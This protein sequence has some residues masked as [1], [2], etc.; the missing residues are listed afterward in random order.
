MT[1]RRHISGSTLGWLAVLVALAAS[2][3]F[4]GLAFGLPHTQTRPDETFIIEAVRALLSGRLPPFFDYPWMYMWLLAPLYVVYYLVGAAGGTFTSLADMVASWPRHWEPFFLIS[5]GLSATAGT[6]T[7]VALFALARRVWDDATA[8]VAAFFLAFAFVHVRDSHFGTTDT[9]MTLFIVAAIYLLVDAHLSGVRWK[10]A[11]AG[12]V[13]GVATA[14][15][16]NAVFLGVPFAASYLL[17]VA[18]APDERRVALGDPRLLLA[19]GAFAI[20][21]AVGVPFVFFDT[22]RFLEAMGKLQESLQS[23]TPW[24]AMSN[25]WV[26]HLT[27]SLRYGIGLPLL[28]VGLIGMVVIA[29]RQPAMALLLFSFP[30]VYFAVA[31][32]LH[33]LFF[34]YA[35]P[36]VP[37]LC[38]AAARIVCLAAAQGVEAVGRIRTRARPQLFG[39]VAAA[40]AVVLALPS[41]VSVWRFD[42]VI[43]QTDNRVVIA[44]WFE[45]YVPAGSSVLQSGSRYGHAQFDRRLGYREWVWDGGRGEFRVNRAAATG[46]PDWILVQESPL[47]STTQEIVKQFLEHDY[48]RVFDFRAANLGGGLLYDMQDAFFVPVTGFDQVT[49]PGPNFVLF[50]RLPAASTGASAADTVDR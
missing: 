18:S 25:G 30:V 8:L 2:V 4:R 23:G 48:Q 9:T 42:R 36:I 33:L 12:L 45:E 41:L 27:F 10:F 35:I 34:R 40:A 26:H 3:R 50:K 38:L 22:A 31:G 5:R 14:T 29:V 47:P 32:S 13:A 44:R 43:S 19:G 1:P 15:K 16:Y 49:R 20:G 46:R 21:L 17:H 6:L 37:F 39:P 7:V 11:A 24:L 28:V